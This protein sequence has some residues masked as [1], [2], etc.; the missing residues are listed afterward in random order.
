[1]KKVL[2]VF[3]AVL[4]AGI[5]N[6]QME[7]DFGVKGGV[8]FAKLTGD[9]VE[10]ADGRT[11]L[12]IG[13]VAESAFNESW[14]LQVEVNYSEQGLEDDDTGVA[15]QLDYINIPVL[16]KYYIAGSGFAIEAGPQIGFVVNDEIELTDTPGP[17]Q[18]VDI[19]AQN[20]D[21]S[22]GGGLSY[23]FKEG[24]SLEGFF[25]QARYMIGFSNVF[26]DD[27]FDD[28]LNNSVLS[29]SLGYVF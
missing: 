13:L 24:T 5:A 17:S 19:D 9:D 27:S 7:W 6:A 22:I 3:V 16:A 20:I 18:E 2:L 21:L 23:K 8:N 12:L 28:D 10:D 15:L 29:L 1:M 11:G 4:T 26:E 25:A 14:G